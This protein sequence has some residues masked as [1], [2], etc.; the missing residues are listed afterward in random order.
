MNRN[1]NILS[2]KCKFRMNRYSLSKPKN[3]TIFQKYNIIDIENNGQILTHNTYLIQE[4]PEEGFFVEWY[5]SWTDENGTLYTC[6]NCKLYFADKNSWLPIS[7]WISSPINKNDID[8]YF[9]IWTNTSWVWTSPYWTGTKYIAYSIDNEYNSFYQGQQKKVWYK[10]IDNNS[11]PSS[12]I[13][14]NNAFFS[15]EV[16]RTIA[17]T[18]ETVVFNYPWLDVTKFEANP[19]ILPA[20]EYFEIILDYYNNADWDDN[21]VVFKLDIPNNL[22]LKKV[23]H[24]WNGKA[25]FAWLTWVEQEITSTQ[26]ISTW[27]NTEWSW[28]ILTFTWADWSNTNGLR[29]PNE[30]MKKLE[31]WRLKLRLMT[32][33]TI[34]SKT[35]LPISYNWTATKSSFK[36]EL[37]DQLQIEIRNAD[38]LLQKSSDITTPI[39]WDIVSYALDLINNWWYKASDV[40]IKDTLLTWLCYVSGTTQILWNWTIWEPNISWICWW[41]QT[42]TRTDIRYN[43]YETWL[44]FVWIPAKLLYK[45][46]VVNSIQN[47]TD[48]TNIATILTPTI[49]DGDYTNTW[50]QTIHVPDADPMVYNIK[51]TQKPFPWENFSYNILYKNNT[52]PTATWVFILHQLPD[53][54]NDGFSDI[55]IKNVDTLNWETI[56]YYSWTITSWTRPTFDYNNPTFWWRTINKTWI[57]NY[58]AIVKWTLWEKEWPYNISIDTIWIIPKTSMLLSP[59]QDLVFKTKIFSTTNDDN[60]TNNEKEDIIP[61]PWLDLSINI[62]ADKKG[63]YPWITPWDSINYNITFAN[64]WPATSC[65]NTV[66]LILDDNIEIN[67]NIDTFHSLQT[68]NLKNFIWE[69]VLPVDKFDIDIT[70]QVNV[71][72]EKIAWTNT[73]KFY[74]WNNKT[75]YKSVCLPKWTSQTFE[76]YAKIKNNTPNDTEAITTTTIFE[77]VALDIEYIL[78]NNTDTTS[79]TVRRADLITNM[80]TIPNTQTTIWQ[81]ETMS[82]KIEYNNIWWTSA[83]TPY[84]TTQIPASTCLDTSTIKLPFWT[85]ILYSKNHAQSRTYTPSTAID[86]NITDTKIIRTNDIEAWNI[87]WEDWASWFSGDD[88]QLLVNWHLELDKFTEVINDVFIPYLWIY[89][90]WNSRILLTWD[91][92][93]DWNLDIVIATDA[94]NT[95][96]KLLIWNWLWDF[97]ISNLPWIK[98]RPQHLLIS[99]IDKDVYKDIIIWNYNNNTEWIEIKSNFYNT[100]LYTT[101][102]ST[103]WTLS[104]RKKLFLDTEIPTNTVKIT[105]D[106]YDEKNSNNTTSINSI[107]WWYPNLY[108][109]IVCDNTTYID[110]QL[111]CTVTYWNN[112]NIPVTNVTLTWIFD[113]NV[114][115]VSNTLWCNNITWTIPN[116]LICTWSTL[117]MSAGSR[118]SFDIILHVNDTLSLLTN[119]TSLKNISKIS[120]TQQEIRME[121]DQWNLLCQLNW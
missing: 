81:N 58:I 115:L 96:N 47:W 28:Y 67:W 44:F 27:V 60:Y 4:I 87:V 13:R 30:E 83:E 91:I 17:N 84:M 86:C 35:V 110:E 121:I 69:I 11:T 111:D 53:Y 104:S 93:N 105:S 63:S 25:V 62:E 33:P 98:N 117:N 46:Q 118:T 20:W 5:G 109:E 101:K 41:E 34:I 89:N 26:Y 99:D 36:T 112:W 82:C 21:T 76:V 29:W 49:E 9:S 75:D 8:T 57:I 80:E 48:I 3:S 12:V 68:I 54:D 32:S 100:W 113:D 72:I 77:N 42:L 2:N 59:W 61:V 74:L 18:V 85:T 51:T 16:L 1:M 95:N 107:V 97:T 102:I 78:D 45:T 114:E 52:R 106:T 6:Q 38:L 66:T 14:S 43:N 56:Y 22:I 116:K 65:A 71:F 23:F 40:T 119:N 39:Q 55:T 31:W 37:N 88:V 90:W 108:T 7:L 10:F 15:N 79:V 24:K 73:Y 19:A 92:N 120:T 94:T 103:T 64:P 70:T 50:Q